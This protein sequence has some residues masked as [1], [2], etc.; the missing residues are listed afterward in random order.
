MLPDEPEGLEQV[1]VE[2]HQAVGLRGQVGFRFE[3]CC[4]GE[5]SFGLFE[6]LFSSLWPI[7]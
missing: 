2:A 3:D 7:L 1:R 4:R 5:E 6:N